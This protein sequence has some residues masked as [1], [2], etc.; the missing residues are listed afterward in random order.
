MALRPV[1][2]FAPLRAG[3]A[4]VPG[5]WTLI[6]L[7][8]A[9]WLLGA[10]PLLVTALGGARELALRPYFTDVAGKLPAAHLLR[11]RDTLGAELLI[12]LGLSLVLVVVAEQV[13]VGGAMAWL[14]PARGRQHARS[15]VG[16]IATAGLA[17]LLVFA[18]VVLMAGALLGLG[19]L[20]LRAAFA[21]LEIHGDPAGWSG[22]SLML[23]LPLAEGTTLVL[24]GS[25]VGAFAFW[26]RLVT[27]ADGRQ[28]LRRTALVVLAVWRRHPLRTAGFYLGVTLALAGLSAGV[29]FLWRQHP[30]RGAGILFWSG[31]W[32]GALVLRS[33]VW[34]WLIRAG[35]LLYAADHLAALRETAD[36]PLH[37]LRWIR[38]TVR[39]YS[40]RVG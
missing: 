11:L 22:R 25:L 19:V 1:Q 30:P 40:R 31:L 6:G 35:R 24:W 13:L 18:R 7:R 33:F 27:V 14:D 39:L 23:T 16:V 5:S 4:A 8:L 3:L 15:V 34:H 37:P 2:P 10:V 26:C 28:R 21:A 17:R 20:L 36:A 38:L 32:L 12:G 29:L 9:V